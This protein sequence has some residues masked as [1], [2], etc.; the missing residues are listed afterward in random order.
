M[1]DDAGAQRSILAAITA[2][3]ALCE[4][5]NRRKEVFPGSPLRLIYAIHEPS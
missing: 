2:L 4:E 5:L 1:D 3:A